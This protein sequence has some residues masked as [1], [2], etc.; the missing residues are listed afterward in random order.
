MRKQQ[1]DGSWLYPGGNKKI[2]TT[3]NYNQLETFRNLGYLVE[4]YAFD[5]RSPAIQKAA[6]WLFSFQT[7]S[8]DIRG[9]LGNQ[10]TPYYTAAMMELLIKAGYGD[11]PRIRKAFGW[12]AYIRQHDGGWT[13]PLRTHNSKLD[14]IAMNTATIEPDRTRPFSHM[15]T[16]IVLRA[17]AA[18]PAF[19]QTAE[20]QAAGKLLLS[21][22]FK[23]DSYPDR[24]A[25]DFW[26]RFTFPFWFTD[27]I[28]AMDSLS[29]LG[30]SENEP[31]MCKAIQWFADNQSPD[32]LWHLKIL[33]NAGYD[34]GL[35]LS[36]AICRILKQLH[37]SN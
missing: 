17:Y 2:R 21:S 6:E 24:S 27:L 37:V 5:K 25:P 32:G 31:R 30:F 16:G 3:E 26:L 1:P 23:K 22:L 12:L 35:W 7:S 28:S 29:L 34:S 11:D 4:M 13:I 18:H 9:I 10:Y 15:V 14:V 8:G 33:K 19:R 20:A 36:L